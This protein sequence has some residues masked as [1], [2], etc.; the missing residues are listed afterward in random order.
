MPDDL[1]AISDPKNPFTGSAVDGGPLE[2]LHWCKDKPLN[3]AQCAH[4][5]W[6]HFEKLE[7]RGWNGC[8]DKDVTKYCKCRYTKNG[9][10]KGTENTLD[11][12][13]VCFCP[14]RGDPEFSVTIPAFP[15]GTGGG[16]NWA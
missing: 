4:Q 2:V 13:G 9:C 16:I 5:C 3:F 11:E 14:N 12:K 7:C 10:V 6:C 8:S 15:S 1:A